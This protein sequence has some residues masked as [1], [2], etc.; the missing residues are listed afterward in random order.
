MNHTTVIAIDGPSGSGKSVLLKLMSGLIKPNSGEV[1][2]RG[3][4]LSTLSKKESHEFLSEVG[5]L[6]QQ[7]ALFDSMT[8][9]ENLD[10]VLSEVRSRAF[11]CPTSGMEI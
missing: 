3:K 11:T 2:Y 4:D 1:F 9:Y 6:F 5:M 7:N 10:F 8:V